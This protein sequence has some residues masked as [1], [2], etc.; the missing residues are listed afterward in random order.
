M[1]YSSF[2]IGGE[3]IMEVGYFPFRRVLWAV[4]ATILLRG[5]IGLL[6][7]A[8][9]SGISSRAELFYWACPLIPF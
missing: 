5:R 6:F 1:K 4:C 7:W 3:L 8:H 2:L 9:S